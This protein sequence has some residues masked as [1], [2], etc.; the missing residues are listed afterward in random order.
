L[1]PPALYLF[2]SHTL[3]SLPPLLP[4][5]HFP[6]ITDPDKGDEEQASPMRITELVSK[7]FSPTLLQFTIKAKEG[8]CCLEVGCA[9]CF[10]QS[11]NMG[12]LRCFL[13][14]MS[15]GDLLFCCS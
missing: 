2:L 14:G 7:R 5:G 10:S 11:E 4:H 12:F 13:Q 3:L 15:L 1:P 8:L 9:H 6:Y